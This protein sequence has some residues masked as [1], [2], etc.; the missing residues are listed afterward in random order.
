MDIRP[1]FFEG[2]WWKS[3]WFFLSC[4]INKCDH[5]TIFIS[6]IGAILSSIGLALVTY[7]YAQHYEPSIVNAA[8]G[9]M[10]QAVSTK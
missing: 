6:C 9:A 2:L 8:E 3:G 4:R 7:S 5:R 1:F 10:Q